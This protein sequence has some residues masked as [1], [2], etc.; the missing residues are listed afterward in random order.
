VLPRR[1][2][3]TNQKDLVN[4][5]EEELTHLKIASEMLY[6]YEGREWEQLFIGG[7]EF[8]SLIKLKSN[9][10]YI[11]EVM[12]TVRNTGYKETM[13]KVDDLPNT[14]DYFKYQR[15]VNTSVN[16][17][18]SHVVIDKYI[19]RNGEDYR[20]EVKPNVEKSLRDRTIDNTDLGRKKGE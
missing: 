7:A 1:N 5:L 10:N 16:Q 6:K 13:V 19:K 12:N 8:P 20:F 3:P 2:A 17:V 9:V 14:A 15:Q 4:A 18:A 11:R